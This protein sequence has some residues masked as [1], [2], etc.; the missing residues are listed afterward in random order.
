MEDLKIKK[1]RKRKPPTVPVGFRIPV[2]LAERLVLMGKVGTICGKVAE[3]FTI[4][5][6]R[7]VSDPELRRV[8]TGNNGVIIYSTELGDDLFHITI[9]KGDSLMIAELSETDIANHIINLVDAL[10]K[11]NKIHI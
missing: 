7:A 6:Q 4:V 5:R 1:Q 11:K 8:V 2:T 10:N 3:Q 9:K